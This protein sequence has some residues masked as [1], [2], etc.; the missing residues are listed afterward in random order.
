MQESYISKKPVKRGEGIAFSE[1][2]ESVAQM[3]RKEFPQISD[4][5]IISLE[6]LNFYRRQYRR[7][8]GICRESE[9]ISSDQASSA[10]KEDTDCRLSSVPN[11]VRDVLEFDFKE[12]IVREF[13]GL[14][15]HQKQ[16]MYLYVEGVP[17]DQ[18]ATLTGVSGG[19]VRSRIHYGKRK[20][21]ERLA[22]FR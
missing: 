2:R 12:A 4:S 10:S 9:F 17:Y 8:E 20:L 3:I 19:T 6:E 16:T 21:R 1:I 18:I 11:P 15:A 22:A 7:V 14:E 5:D 13:A